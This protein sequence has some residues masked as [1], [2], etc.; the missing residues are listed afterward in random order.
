MLRGAIIPD[1]DVAL[2]PVPAHGV[3]GSSDVILQGSAGLTGVWAERNTRES[4]YAVL[5]RRET[6]A[7]KRKLPLPPDMPA[8]LQERAVSSP[9]WYT[10]PTVHPSVRD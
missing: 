2:A 10:P 7:V 3:F 8:T 4:I 5:R 1:S 9:I 6:F